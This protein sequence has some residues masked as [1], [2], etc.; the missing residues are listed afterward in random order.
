MS[1]YAF[2]TCAIIAIVGT[3]ARL[4]IAMSA[5]TPRPPRIEWDDPAEVE[6]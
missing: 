3:V 5:Q 1:D 4:G 6:A 2:L